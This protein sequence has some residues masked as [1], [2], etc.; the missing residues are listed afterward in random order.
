MSTRVGYRALIIDREPWAYRLSQ[1]LGSPEYSNKIIST[2]STVE[3]LNDA[4][5]LVEQHDFL[6]LDPFAFGL[7]DAVRFIADVFARSPVKVFT[8]YRSGRQWQDRARDLESMALTPGKLRTMLFL[9]KDL[10]HDASF[11]QMV[12]NNILSMERELLSELQ[13]SGLNADPGLRGGWAG[14][15]AGQTRIFP[16]SGMGRG[17]LDFSASRVGPMSSPFDLGQP[18]V[19]GPLPAHTYSGL[20]PQ[21]LRELGDYV[22]TVLGRPAPTPTHPIA[23]ML[24]SPDYSQWAQ[25]TATLKEQ[26]T[27]AR[28]QIGQLQQGLGPIQQNL[29][30]TQQSMTELRQGQA[31]LQETLVGMQRDQRDSARLS[32]NIEQRLRELEGRQTKADQQTADLRRTLRMTQIIAFSLSGLLALAAG[33]VLIVLIVGG[34]LGG[35]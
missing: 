1:F 6:Y 30:A 25:Q 10:M 4:H 29:A 26:L 7:A 3:T 19:T 32:S 11:G 22:A 8:L 16:E 34:H 14:G 12:R 33:V 18:Y 20:P 24:P 13:R 9:D 31:K 2:V 23:P 15:D 5:Y 17:G 28:E 21:Q 27:T 35:H